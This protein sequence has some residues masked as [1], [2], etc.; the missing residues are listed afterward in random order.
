MNTEQNSSIASQSK[1]SSLQDTSTNISFTSAIDCDSI[2]STNR[3][4][5][6]GRTTAAIVTSFALPGVDIVICEKAND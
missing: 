4:S 3:P 6:I 1:T 5:T 2:I